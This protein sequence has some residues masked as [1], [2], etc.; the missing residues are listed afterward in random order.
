MQQP[1]CFS[2]ITSQIWKTRNSTVF[3]FTRD[4]DTPSK[5]SINHHQP[6]FQWF[7]RTFRCDA[8]L[9]NAAGLRNVCWVCQ[10][11]IGHSWHKEGQ[12][13][14]VIR[15][16]VKIAAHLLWEDTLNRNSSR[17]LIYCMCVCLR[18]ER[19]QSL[20]SSAVFKLYKIPNL[21]PIVCLCRLLAIWSKNHEI[22]MLESKLRILHKPSMLHH[23]PNT[24]CLCFCWSWSDESSG[25]LYSMNW[26][27][28]THA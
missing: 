10:S 19:Q 6:E 28:V 4:N 12:S 22:Y 24:R 25:L 11:V 16:C 5:S 20:H 14:V 7:G 21:W 1:S 15:K 26:I 9:H 18:E 13:S 3:H 2:F 8:R 17:L 27:T 23:N